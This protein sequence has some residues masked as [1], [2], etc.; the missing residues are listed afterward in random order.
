MERTSTF[1]VAAAGQP[2]HPTQAATAASLLTGTGVTAAPEVVVVAA[3][4]APAAA[5]RVHHAAANVAALTAGRPAAEWGLGGEGPPWGGLGDYAR[6]TVGGT[7]A[8]VA[9]VTGGVGGAG[10]GT[11]GGAHVEGGGENCDHEGN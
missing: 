1:I 7:L 10:G 2:R 5:L 11:M 6:Y 4:A 3:T 9:A 8:A